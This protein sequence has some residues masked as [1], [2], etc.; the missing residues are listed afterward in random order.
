VAGA[1]LCH[2]FVGPQPI[3]IRRALILM[4]QVALALSHLHSK[5]LIHRDLKPANILIG[6]DDIVKLT[7]F[8]LAI[9]DDMP[10]WNQ[11][12]IAG[13]QRYMAPEQVLGE[14]HRIDGRTDIWGFGVV[15]Y[16]LLTSKPPF[17]ATDPKTL[18]QSILKGNAPSLR[19]RRPDVP[20][21]L[22][23]FCLRCLSQCMTDRYQ[24]ATELLE[25]LET[26]QSSLEESHV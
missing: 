8:G 2:E 17:R 21:S 4:R 1:T 3:S 16:E 25:D 10:A 13:T 24:S 14:T 11:Q 26:V 5:G 9:S 6:Q 15:L 23:Q 18:F 20:Q 12:Q 22:D 19:Q 7:D